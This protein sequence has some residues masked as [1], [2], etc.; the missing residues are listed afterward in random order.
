MSD[1]AGDEPRLELGLRTK[2][3]WW[4]ACLVGA[5]VLFAAYRTHF[6]NDDAWITYRY[7]E[8]LAKGLGFVFNP[9]E[10]VLGTSTPLY[11]CILALVHAAGLPVPITSQALGYLSMLGIL[12]GTYLLMSRIHSELAGLLAIALLVPIQVFHRI[13]TYGMETPLYTLCIV[14][15]FYAYSIDRLRLTTVLAACALLFRLDGAAVGAALI[16]AYGL[17]RRELPWKHMLLFVALTAPWFIFSYLYFGTFFPSS[18]WAKR[19][20]TG[21]HY[22][23]WILK[24]LATLLLTPFALLGAGVCLR[25]P[26][27][28]SRG[29]P[30]AIW[31]A[32]YVAAYSLSKL[33]GYEWYR[34]PMTVPLAGFG[35]VGVL[36]AAGALR[37]FRLAPVWSIAGLTLL[38]VWTDGSLWSGMHRLVTGKGDWRD[39]LESGRYEASVWMRDNLPADAMIVT[40]GIGQIG[41]VTQ[42]YILDA[43]GLISPQVVVEGLPQAWPRFLPYIVEHYRPEYVFTVSRGVP[44]Y[45]ADDYSITRTWQTWY[46]GGPFVLMQRNASA[47]RE[48]VG[49][50]GPG[51]SG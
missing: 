33:P 31:M 30:F 29:L 36:A 8:N 26:E 50:P 9:G 15:A 41:Y 21:S 24:W 3:A 11:T 13:A 47:S 1:E 14:F 37:R 2:V 43:S 6:A 51:G 22:Q 27:R 12:V 5:T 49:A 20:H 7:A 45:M 46:Q 18:F 32:G 40:G 39:R 48:G 16:L 10:R 35:A 28:R 4:T 25:T 19:A 17:N 44:S 34:T 23:L 38:L 42:R